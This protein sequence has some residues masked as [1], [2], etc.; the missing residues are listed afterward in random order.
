MKNHF[1]EVLFELPI[2][3]FGFWPQHL[4]SQVKNLSC[5]TLWTSISLRFVALL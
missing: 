3:K 4:A 5:A 1:F 2:D